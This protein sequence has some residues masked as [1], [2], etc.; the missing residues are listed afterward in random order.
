MIFKQVEDQV[1]LSFINIE[2]NKKDS[3]TLSIKIKFLI[4][5]YALYFFMRNNLNFFVSSSGQQ[6]KIIVKERSLILRSSQQKCE[7]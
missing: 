7:P 3:L 1:E 5:W 6:T 4:K 2:R